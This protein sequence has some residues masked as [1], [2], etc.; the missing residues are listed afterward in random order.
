MFPLTHKVDVYRFAVSGGQDKYD[1][2]PIITGLDVAIYPAS[3]DI[4]AVYPGESAYQLYEIYT[5]EAVMLKN[6]DKLKVGTD[7]WI[8][9][10]APREFRAP[11]VYY[12]QLV[13]EKVV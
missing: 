8:V 9:R 4:L 11:F 12:V 10:G 5:R 7:E 6:G 2:T 3:T 1:S 13:G